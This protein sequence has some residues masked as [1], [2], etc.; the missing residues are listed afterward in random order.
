MRHRSQEL[1]QSAN[2]SRANR[3]LSARDVAARG[4]F[5][6]V[7]SAKLVSGRPK[8]K[9]PIRKRRTRRDPASR[10]SPSKSESRP[11]PTE[12]YRLTERG[13]LMEAATVRER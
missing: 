11:K 4:A 6:L 2:G 8:Q 9:L 7:G 10:W 3:R 5:P 13:L 1:H 12:K